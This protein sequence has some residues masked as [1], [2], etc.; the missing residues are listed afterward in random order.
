M[1]VKA[2]IPRGPFGASGF[3]RRIGTVQGTAGKVG[4][5]AGRM[6]GDIR[7]PLYRNA[8]FIML[9]SLIG[10]GLGFFFILMVTRVYSDTD[11]GAALT[12]ISTIG[13]LGAVALLGFNFGLIRFLPGTE[14]RPALVNECLSIAGVLALVL[15]VVFALGTNV[16]AP[17]LAFVLDSPVY[18]V[19]IAITAMAYAFSPIL[20][21]AAVASRR[22]D[23]ATW[24][25]TIF[26][27]LKV[28]MP[29]LMV[30]FLPGRLGIYMSWSIALGISVLI[31]GFLFLPT[32]I[33]HYRPVP[34][35]RGVQ[36]RPIFSFS[37]GNWVASVIGLSATL[38]LPLLV[39]NTLGYA[40][41]AYFWV[42]FA[43]ASI[44]YVIPAA[45]TTS[46]LAE[47][48]QANAHRRR[49]E[50]KAILL[51]MALLA[52]A[53]VGIWFLAETILGLFGPPEYAI[54]GA[55]PARIL[56]LASIPIF[57][58]GLLGTRIRIKK[59]VWPIILA[60]TVEA[61][62]VL[63]LGYVL[64]GQMGLEGL[65][66]AYLLGSTAQVPILFLAARG[67]IE[68]EEIEPAAVPP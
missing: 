31:A 48:S 13:F 55:A 57:L 14:D 7:G 50:R 43:V 65:A 60:V 59:K 28:P 51:S 35:F 23:L 46:L 6:W 63:G 30:P 41:A 67:P 18:V 15:A 21:S 20:D 9:S 27:A 53:I 2:F 56:A 49:D 62:V 5:L 11:V 10:A 39:T 45:T 36:V 52:P 29:L 33:A 68:I 1:T 4:R 25:I 58:V 42:A 24:R 32:V 66:W 64:L 22:A 47:S 38:L 44:L 19:L 54:E 26:S 12:L 37:L 40:Q 16:W 8:L 3:V 17:A 34:R 61:V